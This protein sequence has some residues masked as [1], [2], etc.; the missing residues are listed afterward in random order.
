VKEVQGNDTAENGSTYRLNGDKST[1][2]RYSYWR[3]HIFFITSLLVYILGVFNTF[4]FF[5]YAIFE[6][7]LLCSPLYRI[8]KALTKIENKILTQINAD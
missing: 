3:A 8:R 5:H 6:I 4:G 1:H 7:V 2:C